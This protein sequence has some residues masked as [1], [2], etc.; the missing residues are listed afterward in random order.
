MFFSSFTFDHY[1]INVHFHRT[2]DQGLKDLCN[3]SLVG[4]VSVLE[5]ERHDF[6][7]IKSMRRYKDSFF[8]VRRGHRDL[9]VSGESI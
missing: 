9:M 7:A 2:I 4:D 1:V 6:V 5:S 8:L 3:Q